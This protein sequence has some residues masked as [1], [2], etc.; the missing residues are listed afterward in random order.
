[1][2]FT[3]RSPLLGMIDILA[4]DAAVLIYTIKTYRT[5]RV[6]AWLFVPYLAWLVIATYL[7]GYIMIANW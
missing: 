3:L 5:S 1:L 2:F 6:S 7:N 4:L